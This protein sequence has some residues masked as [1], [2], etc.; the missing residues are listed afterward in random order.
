LLSRE[1]F[2]IAV[3]KQTGSKCSETPKKQPYQVFFHALLELY[4]KIVTS[5]NLLGIAFLGS[6]SYQKEHSPL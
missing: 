1:S 5:T 2:G 6:L 4:Q 3:E